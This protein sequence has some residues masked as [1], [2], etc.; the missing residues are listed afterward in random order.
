MTAVMRPRATIEILERL[1]EEFPVEEWRVGELPAWPIVR[2][3]VGHRIALRMIGT[4]PL[5]TGERIRRE[6]AHAGSFPALLWDRATSFPRQPADVVFFSDGVSFLSHG[7]A[8]R[9]RHSDPIRDHLDAR[10]VSSLLLVPGHRHRNPRQ[11]SVHVQ[12]SLDGR[13]ALARLRRRQPTLPE[14]ERLRAALDA[15]DTTVADDLPSSA[16]I[17]LAAAEISSCAR[18]FDWA[19]T[20]AGARAG[21]VVEY[22]SRQGMAFVVACHRRGIP[23]VDIQH[24]VQRPHHHAYQSWRAIPAGGSPLLPSH[25]WVWT[26]DDRAAIDAWAAVTGDAHV[27]VVGG[28]PDRD[29]WRFRGPREQAELTRFA[30]Q[31]PL[32]CTGP[33][34]VWTLHTGETTED[35][36]TIVDVAAK[37]PEWWWWV[38]AHPVA[39]GTAHA[40][41]KVAAERGLT[42]VTCDDAT[43]IPLYALL[44]LSDV[45]V[46]AYSSTVLDAK[47]LG[48][49]S[50]IIDETGEMIFSDEISSGWA[51]PA[52]TGDAS[53]IVAAA[54]QALARRRDA[55]TDT[56]TSDAGAA[57]DVIL[58]AARIASGSP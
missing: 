52:A 3:E 37:T 18:F 26:D 14:Y 32:A 42:N 43:T 35:I 47:A 28:N 45:H 58:D 5:S 30:A 41:A 22:Y 9:D 39:P 44:C 40:V 34:A 13:R 50:V 19:L 27:A 1:E 2:M 55:D 33:T 56:V 36:A 20:R 8:D 51:F 25:F 23:V 29:R 53:A 10:G 11:P 46:T 21:F 49:A 17:A 4:R 24:G 38:R 7:G 57:L 6:A 12:P 54:S 48:V 15:N 31:R 16:A